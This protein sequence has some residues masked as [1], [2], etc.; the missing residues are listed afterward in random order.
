MIICSI[1]HLTLPAA[2][3]LPRRLSMMTASGIFASCRGTSLRCHD[4]RQNTTR[5]NYLRSSGTKGPRICCC[6]TIELS[7]AATLPARLLGTYC[8]RQSDILPVTS[9]CNL[10]GFA[11]VHHAE[12]GRHHQRRYSPRP[13]TSQARTGYREPLQPSGLDPIRR[14]CSGICPGGDTI[15][16]C[17]KTRLCSLRKRL[18]D[19]RPLPTPYVFTSCYPNCP[20]ACVVRCWANLIAPGSVLGI[21]TRGDFNHP[22]E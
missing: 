16:F 13:Y 4:G 1:G 8:I 7:S 12:S 2:Y 20:T 9:L 5:S 15:L 18:T 14:L 10:R 6:A 11:T 21:S 3:L 19:G 17:R 22:H